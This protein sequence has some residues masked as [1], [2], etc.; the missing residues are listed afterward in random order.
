M[1]DG[2]DDREFISS[3]NEMI[4]QWTLFSDFKPRCHFDLLYPIDL[5][6]QG[7]SIRPLSSVRGIPVCSR[8]GD[9][10]SYTWVYFP[11]PSI[12]LSP[13]IHQKDHELSEVVISF[14]VWSV[15]LLLTFEYGG[16]YL[17]LSVV[18]LFNYMTRC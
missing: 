6:G 16:P 17:G 3:T 7:D 4:C 15:K 13:P 9:E 1:I 12:G 10:K 11:D 14:L 5:T 18:L 8:V 2:K